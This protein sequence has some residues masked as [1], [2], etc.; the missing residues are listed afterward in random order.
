MEEV[1]GWIETV[2]GYSGMEGVELVIEAV[3]KHIDA[4]EGVGAGCARGDPGFPFFPIISNRA[5][6]GK[7]VLP[8]LLLCGIVRSAGGIARPFFLR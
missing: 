3:I 7:Q 5:A 1:I 4:V 2:T 8:P 6:A